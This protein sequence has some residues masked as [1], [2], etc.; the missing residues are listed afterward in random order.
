[1]PFKGEIGS[2]LLELQYLT[3]L[4]LSLF[5]GSET[6]IPKFIGSLTNL[7]YLNFSGCNFIGTIPY[8]LGNLTRLVSLD[9]S[10]NNFDKVES[11]MFLSHLPALKHLEMRYT[12]LRQTT[13][14]LR[15][16]NMLHSLLNLHL[17]GCGLSVVIPPPLS[18]ANSSKS[19]A[20]IDFCVNEFSSS[21]FPWLL[22]FNNSLLSLNL[23]LNQLQG[24][25]PDTFGNM[26]ALQH[27]NL[28][29]NH[30]EGRIP[31]SLGNPFSLETLDLSWNNLTGEVPN[32]SNF[33]FIKELRLPMNK[34]NGSLTESTDL[35]SNLEVMDISSNSMNGVI[36]DIHFLTLSKLRHLDISLNSF[37][38]NLSS[39]WVP[40]FQLDILIMSS[41]K[42]LEPHFPQW[43]QTQKRIIHLDIS[44]SRIS[45]GISDWF[46]ELP[47]ILM[48]LN[49]SGNLICGE[50]QKLPFIVDNFSAIDMSSNCFHGSKPPLPPNIT[51]LNLSGNRFSRNASNLCSISGEYL[52][53]LDVS[54]NSL[55]GEL[56]DCWTNWKKLGILNLANNNFSGSIPASLALLPI[57]AL[58][59]RNNCF[60][61]EL[62]PS[63]SNC[64]GLKFLDVGENRLFGTIPAWIGENLPSLIVLRLRSN[65]IYGS[66]HLQL[67]HLTSLQILDLSN[68]S[69]SGGIP[70]CL[71]NFTA[72]ASNSGTVEIFDNSYS[73]LLDPW[74]TKGWYKDVP[75]VNIVM[76]LWKGT[77][78]EYG[79]TLG[80]VKCID[81]SSN[82]FSGKIPG[83][84]TRLVG[85]LSLNLSN[86]Q[87]TGVIPHSIGHLNLLESLDLSANHLSGNAGLCGE[88]LP[89]RCPGEKVA[90][91]SINRGSENTDKRVGK[92]EIITSGFYISMGVGF[93]TGFWGVC[94]SLLLYRP[95]RHAYFHF[96]DR[97]GSWLYVRAVI[98]IA[99]LQRML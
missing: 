44:N 78:R 59:L 80:L 15:A 77:E 35:L 31:I 48:Y 17:S 21:I 32:L 66:L 82:N 69:I 26:I 71:S 25:I 94:C 84:I 12:N 95:W 20:I 9:L 87:L 88:P 73:Y 5:E 81:F 97:V 62:P 39:Y 1:M 40:P 30:L 19:L 57:E 49:L 37:T 11:L 29:F 52:N 90:R 96:L 70:Q 65:R 93:A 63:L 2:S 86:N 7:R 68:N 60:S 3:Y 61:G 72:M 51:V 6:S 91:P 23:E 45:D 99:K 33:S 42:Q 67:C 98:S 76:I 58:Q 46:W 22:N 13:D 24:Q 64:T 14:W 41:C 92:R 10:F 8:Q 56:P 16:I 43:L 38:L 89:N 74:T 83:E 50:V 36:S 75:Y 18:L 34:L 4:D 27:L 79:N 28:A 47:P 55:S 85:L 53:N 54:D